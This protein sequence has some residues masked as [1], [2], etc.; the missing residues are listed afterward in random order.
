ML[1]VCF[2]DYGE[3]IEVQKKGEAEGIWGIWKALA[4]DIFAQ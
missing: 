3:A 2:N 4:P 1:T